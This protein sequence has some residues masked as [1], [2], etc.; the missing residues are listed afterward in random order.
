[1]H[2]STTFWNILEE[3]VYLSKNFP[4]STPFLY[5]FFSQPEYKSHIWLFSKIIYLVVFKICW[6]YSLNLIP[7][8]RSSGYKITITSGLNWLP[9]QQFPA[10]KAS[11]EL[12]EGQKDLLTFL[13]QRLKHTGKAVWKNSVFVKYIRTGQTEEVHPHHYPDSHGPRAGAWWKRKSTWR[14]FLLQTLGAVS[15]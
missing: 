10:Q 8:G 11:T 7:K 9:Y 14:Y 15:A 4:P 5:Y 12:S 6:D 13:P 3:R 1:M 2:S